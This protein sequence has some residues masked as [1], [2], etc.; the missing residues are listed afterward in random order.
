MVPR[1]FKIA[2]SISHRRIAPL[3]SREP[4]SAGGLPIL[5]WTFQGAGR[6]EMAFRDGQSL[7]MPQ[8]G[9]RD[10]F[11]GDGQVASRR[12]HIPFCGDAS[13]QKAECV[14]EK[15]PM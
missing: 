7:F 12:G 8:S 13:V 4:P 3:E 9:E 6:I 5:E 15:L 11:S 2:A 1:N 14:L 10:I